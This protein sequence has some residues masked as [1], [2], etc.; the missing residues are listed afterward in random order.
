M[1]NCFLEAI[2]FNSDSIDVVICLYVDR[3]SDFLTVIRTGS[4]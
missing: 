1:V 2:S 4:K 3:S